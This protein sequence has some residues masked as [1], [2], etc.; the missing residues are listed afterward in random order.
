[1]YSL[2]K[3]G[4]FKK[5]RSTPGYAPRLLMQILANINVFA[6]PYPECPAFAYGGGG[7]MNTL[8]SFYGA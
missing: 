3:N 2:E 1:M 6:N 8:N 5:P 7:R 4:D